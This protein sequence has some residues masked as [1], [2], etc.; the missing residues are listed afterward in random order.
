[1]CRLC[2]RKGFSLVELLV[3]IAIIAVIVAIITPVLV[4]A[5]R[6]ANIRSSQSKLHQLSIALLIYRTD[7]G[8]DGIY[9]SMEQMGL[10][11]ARYVYISRFHQF[12]SD[13][14]VSSCGHH[15]SFPVKFNIDYIPGE[16]GGPFQSQSVVFRENMLMFSDM[17]CTPSNI[18]LSNPYLIKYGLGVLLSGRLVVKNK[19]GRQSLPDWWADPEL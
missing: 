7:H 16:G 3:V 12:S 6:S 11:P 18:N 2:L 13:M 4:Q 9:G 10:P 14:L 1:M 15:P 5:K 17:N 19:T 8:G